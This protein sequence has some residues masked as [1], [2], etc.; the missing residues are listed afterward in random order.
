MYFTS[1]ETNLTCFESYFRLYL[2][3][4]QTSIGFTLTPLYNCYSDCKSQ[5]VIL[6]RVN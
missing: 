2:K 3:L 1:T 4:E 6:H 5:I